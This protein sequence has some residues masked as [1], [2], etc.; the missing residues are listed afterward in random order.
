MDTL[1]GTMAYTDGMPATDAAIYVEGLTTDAAGN[2]YLADDNY[3]LQLNTAGFL[4]TI[5]GTGTGSLTYTG[6]GGP[7]TAAIVIGAT[8][9]ALDGSGNVFFTDEDF[10]SIHKVNTAGIISTIAGNN[11]STGGYG[12]DG[13]PASVSILNYPGG[14]H[15]DATGNIY[16]CDDYNNRVRKINSITG[17]INT[18]IGD[19]RPGYTG[20]GG[21]ATAA[22]IWESSTGS[23][24][25]MAMDCAGN[26]YIT[27][28]VGCTVRKVT[29]IHT[30]QYTGE[31]N[32]LT[33]CEN[34][35]GTPINGLLQ[36]V[37]SG[38]AEPIN[39]SVTTAPAHGSIGG[40]T[41]SSTTTGGMITPSG[42]TY[43]P[44]TG[45]TGS[46]SFTIMVGY[47][48]QVSDLKTI[49][50]TVNALPHP[51]LQT[52][53]CSVPNVY[54]SYQWYAASGTP[55]T[56]ATS[57]TCG[58]CGMGS[59]YVVVD[60]NG[61]SGTSDIGKVLEGINNVNNESYDVSVYPNPA[62][63]ELTVTSNGMISTVTVSNLVGQQVYTHE[64]QLSQAHVDISGLPAGVYFVKVNGAVV[65]KVVIN[66]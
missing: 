59:W 44:S 35:G 31:G 58:G 50:V 66:K 2:L 65:R 46:D 19:G 45:Y 9:I 47:C 18:I 53:C 23:G 26:I 28:A 10:N 24:G 16:V 4:H 51:V 64:Y 60:S 29:Y 30:P 42:L 41:Y 12:G 63:N 1:S 39:W 55:L 17:N 48:S 62:T 15:T 25:S 38:I 13:G 49:Y 3:V 33:V 8:G 27:D 11:M 32:S 14:V 40:A 20:D 36:A 7:A 52:P 6:D 5:A 21:P 22:E 34:T 56:G 54:S 37:D 61:C 57:A 43:T